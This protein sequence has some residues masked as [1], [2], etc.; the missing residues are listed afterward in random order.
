[1]TNIHESE[2]TW[3]PISVQ[4]GEWIQYESSRKW[5]PVVKSHN[6]RPENSVRHLVKH[7]DSC[8]PTSNKYMLLNNLND[9]ARPKLSDTAVKNRKSAVAKVKNTG[10]C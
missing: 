10:L 7:N 1:M 3:Q 5:T 8:I 6:R 9:S 4:C 2:S